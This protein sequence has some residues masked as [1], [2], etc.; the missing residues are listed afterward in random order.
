M[1]PLWWAVCV[2]VVFISARNIVSHA[3]PKLRATVP[4]VSWSARVEL[5]RQLL[6]A[7]DAATF[8]MDDNLGA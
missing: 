8:W 1:R 4:A 5:A 7:E 3:W 6:E 2:L